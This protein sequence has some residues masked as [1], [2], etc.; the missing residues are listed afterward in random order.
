[1]DISSIY[2]KL[3]EYFKY[4]I[5]NNEYELETIV[6]SKIKNEK[7]EKIFQYLLDEYELI[8]DNDNESL[9]IRIVSLKKFEKYRLTIK[10]KENIL[11]YCKT[12][13]CNEKI[14]EFG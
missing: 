6:T 12:N 7:F 9:D 5:E 2:S 3:K 13:E 11:R 8:S 1:M 14:L 4:S 10:G